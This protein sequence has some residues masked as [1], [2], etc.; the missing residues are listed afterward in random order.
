VLPDG[1]LDEAWT[2]DL[3]GLT[4]GRFVMNFRY[5]R[6][7]KAIGNVV[8]HEALGL[9]FQGEYDS[10]IEDRL[11]DGGYID[12]WLFDLVANTAQPI[13]G[14]DDAIRPALQSEV[15]DDRIFIFLAD[16][17]GSRTKI[18]ELADDATATL[19]YEMTGD[20]YKLERLR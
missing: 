4:G 7:G 10:A 9:D 16:E 12:A 19:K 1:T 13:T 11:W 15:V 2:T 20:V 3:T 8:D 17:E 18:Y 14:M 5:L 6:G